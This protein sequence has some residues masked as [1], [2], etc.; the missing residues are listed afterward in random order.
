M[1]K[2]LSMV[3]SVMM[4]LSLGACGKKEE[5][6]GSEAKADNQFT[7]EW[8]GVGGDMFGMAM[9]VEEASAY[10]LTVNGDG[11]AVLNTDGEPL[12][13]TWTSADDTI[14]LKVDALEIETAGN[15]ADGAIYFE[16]LMGFGV[17]IYFAKEGTDAADPSLY[18]PEADKA[19]VGTWTSYAV[20]DVLGDDMSATV[21]A[22]SLKLTFKGDYTV[23]VEI[24]AEKFEGETWSLMESFGYLAD[25]DCDISW[26]VVGDEIEV[27]YSGDDY[28]VFTC[29]KTE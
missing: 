14:T 23:D 27:T 16:D 17:N 5:Q 6:K 12:D 25:S 11:K 3:L 26:D 28:L 21:P 18:I 10:T 1:K 8:I 22:D 4:I 13:T 20:A 2:I 29:R 9:T 15:L 24:G 7:G 19:M